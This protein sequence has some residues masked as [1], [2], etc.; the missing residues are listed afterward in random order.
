M[1]ERDMIGAF[2]IVKRLEVAAKYD[3]NGI[4]RAAL[5]EI[6]RL[7]SAL[8]AMEL[9]EGW[10]WTEARKGDHPVLRDP[11][12]YELDGKWCADFRGENY[13]QHSTTR[14][15]MAALD[16]QKASPESTP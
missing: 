16:A 1:S 13:G 9:P 12:V 14:E 2:E 8:E 15:A 11:T 3:T 10:R 4:Y 5:S 7:A 6:R